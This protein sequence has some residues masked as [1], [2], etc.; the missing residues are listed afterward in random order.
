MSEDFQS[1][2]NQLKSR[3]AMIESEFQADKDLFAKIESVNHDAISSLLDRQSRVADLAKSSATLGSQIQ[4]L[5][6]SLPTDCDAHG[7]LQIPECWTL[8]SYAGSCSRSCRL[9]NGVPR[10]IS[11]ESNN[12]LTVWLCQ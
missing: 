9:Q 1:E 7:C 11:G 6:S 10:P 5:K 2:L 3:L 8:D 4:D 12:I